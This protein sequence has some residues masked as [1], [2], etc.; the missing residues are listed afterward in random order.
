M[1]VVCWIL[2]I[3]VVCLTIVSNVLDYADYNHGTCPHCGCDWIFGH[4]DKSSGYRHY[5]CDKCHEEINISWNW[6]DR[7]RRKKKK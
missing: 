2:A 4:E 7:D 1:T 5:F 3:L 6:V